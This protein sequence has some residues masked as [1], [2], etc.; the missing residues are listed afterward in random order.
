MTTGVLGSSRL[1]RRLCPGV[2]AVA[3]VAVVVAGAPAAAAAALVGVPQVASA[4]AAGPLTAPDAVSA[5]VMARLENQPVEVLGERTEFGSVY[6]LA[7]GMMAAGQGSGPVWVRHGGDG[8]KIEDWA[9]VDLTLVAGTDGLVRPVAQSGALVLAGGTDRTPAETVAPSAVVD[10]ASVTDPGTG[11]KTR[12]AWTGELP[13]PEL[14]G[15]RATYANVQPG[16]DMV[17]EAT[18]RGCQIFC[19]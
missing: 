3:A 4:R 1:W 10:V 15:R 9:A 5:R 14:Q 17:I 11:I 2:A 19:V 16:V 12:V 7:D 18:S 13:T 8:T 6:A